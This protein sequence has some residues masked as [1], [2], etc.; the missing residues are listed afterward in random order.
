MSSPVTQADGIV[1]LYFLTTNTTLSANE[2]VTLTLPNV[3][4][5]AAEVAEQPELSFYVQSLLIKERL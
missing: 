4:A 1:S 5:S 3:S 2:V